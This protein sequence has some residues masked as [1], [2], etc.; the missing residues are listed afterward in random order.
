MA[1]VVGGAR[2]AEA[3][4]PGRFER[5]R[6]ARLKT[7]LE[8]ANEA[9][10]AGLPHSSRGSSPRDPR[11]PT[12]Q[13]SHSTL[14]RVARPPTD[15]A[16]PFADRIHIAPSPFQGDPKNALRPSTGGLDCVPTLWPLSGKPDGL[17][18]S[19]AP[20]LFPARI[21]PEDRFPVCCDRGTVALR[22][23]NSIFQTHSP[24]VF[25]NANGAQ[26]AGLPHS[27]RGSSPRDPRNPTPQPPHS[28]LK[29]SHDHP[30]IPPPTPKQ[31]LK[32]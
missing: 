14:K 19:I 18:K 12:P 10:P 2:L 21:L 8:N 20:C 32:A 7:C 13:P 17:R 16:P 5:K 15:S 27:S 6:P 1:S 31:A 30:P 28:T 29:G 23:Q 25:G 22:S 11:N 24:G 26:P 3:A 9:Q 4:S